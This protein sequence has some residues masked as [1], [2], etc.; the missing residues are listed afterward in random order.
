MSGVSEGSR[1]F[2][3]MLVMLL[4]VLAKMMS[5][6]LPVSTKI[7]PMVQPAMLALM[8]MASLCG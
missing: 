6:D 1:V 4:S 3:L 8:A 7:L 5:T 2:G